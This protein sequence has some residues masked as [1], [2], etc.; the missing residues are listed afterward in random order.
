M[1]SV[2]PLEVASSNLA[3]AEALRTG[4]SSKRTANA[5]DPSFQEDTEVRSE[6]PQANPEGRK[7]S[8]KPPAID[9]TQERVRRA[10]RAHSESTRSRWLS[11]WD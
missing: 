5:S 1:S 9:Q 6:K 8:R 11:A 3:P 2:D 7:A 4:R 10:S